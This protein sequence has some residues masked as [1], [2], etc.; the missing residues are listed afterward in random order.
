[1]ADAPHPPPKPPFAAADAG[2]R[3]DCSHLTPLVAKA[4]ERELRKAPAYPEEKIARLVDAIRYGVDI[5]YRGDRRRGRRADNSRTTADPRVAELISAA[6]AVDVEAGYKRGPFDA[7]PFTPFHVSPLSGVPKGEDGIRVIH[8]L[9]HPF[10]GDSINAGIEREVYIMQRFEDAIAAIRRLGRGCRLSKF[11]VRAAFKLVPVRPEDRPLLGLVW[12]GK[13]YYEVVLPFGL[14]TSGYRWEEFAEALHFLCTEHLGIELV[15]H[16]VDDFLFVAP[17]ADGVRAE[18]ER[19]AFEA[20]CRIL[21]VPIADEK[22]VGPATR[23]VFLGIEIDTDKMECR[24]TDKRVGKLRSLLQAWAAADHQFTFEELASLVGKLEFATTVIRP[25][26]AFLRCMRGYMMDLKRARAAGGNE[27]RRLGVAALLEVR[28]WLDAFLTSAG[29]RR[30]I[31]E[32]PWLLDADMELYTDACDTGY[33]ACFGN[34]WFQGRWTPAQLEFARVHTRISM[35]FLELHALTHA[36]VT[37]GHLW[38]GKRITFRCDAE[39]AVIAVQK[40]RSRKDSMSA[41]LRLLYATSVRHD[42]LFRCVHV[43]G[44]TNVVADALSRGCSLQELRRVQ[45]S[46]EAEPTPA[47]P[48]QLDGEDM[49]P[50]KEEPLGQPPAGPPLWQL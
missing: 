8:N 39:A 36:A 47:P 6:I 45:P 13:Y 42:F 2:E 27:R 25:G 11:D 46:A 50:W 29:N 23:C 49:V 18:R 37:W 20:L 10:G 5:G 26:T 35:P 7:P 19:Q 32:Q 4:W 31:I 15:F 43:P 24:L 3:E 9:S 28:W 41:L 17:P 14:R 44:V 33:G 40:M 16:Y 30:A 1:M 12:Q 34:R 22:T 48:L 21:G 38:R